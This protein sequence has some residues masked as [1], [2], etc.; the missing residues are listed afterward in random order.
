MYF[1][2]GEQPPSSKRCLA[3]GS[4]LIDKMVTGQLI[5]A[6]FPLAI[7]ASE[8]AFL[9][10]EE[11]RQQDLKQAKLR[12]Q[13]AEYQA[14]RVLEQ[15]DLVDPKNRLVALSLEERL[16]QRLAELHDAK[17]QL[18]ILEQDKPPMSEEQK[19]AIYELAENFDKL[20]HHPNAPIGIRKRL[21]RTAIEE[22]VVSHIPDKKPLDVVIH[23]K[24]GNHTTFE[25]PKPPSGVGRKTGLAGLRYHR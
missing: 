4:H 9:R 25:M 1:C 10:H 15:Y 11:T 16:N 6:I 14:E 22:I 24:G 21:V 7:Q 23:W 3:F 12:V 20:W 8:T 2:S 5:E 19:N 13:A 17:G 18:R